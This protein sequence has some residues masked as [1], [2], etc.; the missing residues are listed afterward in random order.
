L[1]SAI[2]AS[3]ALQNL[4]HAMMDGIGYGNESIRVAIQ[5]QIFAAYEYIS[6][7]ESQ[8]KQTT[9]SGGYGFDFYRARHWK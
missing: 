7:W 2:V 4:P 1:T 5:L 6:L 3:F 9:D 8:H